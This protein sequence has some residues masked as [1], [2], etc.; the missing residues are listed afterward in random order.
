MTKQEV[1]D[2]I[3]E[4]IVANGSNEITANVLRPILTAILTQ[5]N[6]YIGD[7]EQLNTVEQSDLVSAINELAESITTIAN[8]GVKLHEG[9]SN[10]NDTTPSS[11]SIADFY[12]QKDTFN[13]PIQLWQ[14]NGISWI[15]VGN[16]INFNAFAY[17]EKK[18][19]YA[20]S[21]SFNLPN[22]VQAISVR[23]NGEPTD[24]NIEDWGQLG[25]VVTYL[26]TLEVGDY[27]IIGGIYNIEGGTSS[28]S[29]NSVNDDD[30]GVVSVDNS[31]Q[32]NPIIKFNGVY[33]DGTTVTGNGTEENP[34]ASLGGGGGVTINDETPSLTQT[35]S[36][37]KSEDT[38]VKRSGTEV[39][40]PVTGDVEIGDGISLIAEEVGGITSFLK[41]KGGKWKIEI[42][43][44][45][46]D[47]VITFD[48]D[49]GIFS[50]KLFDIENDEKAYLQKG[51]IIQLEEDVF[52]LEL[53]KADLVGGL[54]PSSQLPAYVDDI[55]E[56]YLLSGVF[57]KENTH[58]TAITG[59]IGKIYVDLTT[60]QKSRQY[61]WSGTVYIQITNGLIASTDDVIEGSNLYFTTARVLATVLTGI[62]FLT[63]GAI[64]STDSILV[65]FG[66]VQ[67]QLNDFSTAIGLKQDALTDT[68]FGT[69]TN[70]VAD[71]NTQSDTDVLAYVDITTGKWVKQTFSNFVDYLKGFFQTSRII[72]TSNITAVNGSIYHNNGNNT[73]TDP[74]PENNKGFSVKVISGTATIGGIDFGIGTIIERDYDGTDWKNEVYV[75]AKN[76][77]EFSG[78]K[79]V[80]TTW[81]GKE[82]TCV[83]SGVL[84]IPASLPDE[85]NFCLRADAGVSISWAITSPHTW[86]VMGLAVGVA[87]ATMTAGQF[88][89]VSKRKGTSE[90]RIS[91]L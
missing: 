45:I 66:K 32:T 27:L 44:G 23:K 79:T 65:A 42:E 62:S 48:I 63:G 40:K 72:V 89:Q 6:N 56:G 38:F 54:V 2:L 75:S 11:Y 37:E 51:H 80:V 10:P 31:N 70:S 29:V 76:Q 12:I 73:F 77:V 39:G 84:T 59:E 86:R 25:N 83:S 7:L 67:K 47:I 60:G 14:F 55:I 88:C 85:F 26:G 3:N 30:N 41:S 90:I 4:F 36:S 34:L 18:I 57:Y 46:T 52:N 21:N 43:D 81:F 68:N 15:E 28:G 19:F 1:L 91:G 5:P 24:V 35:Y 17:P 69:F 16:N 74:T 82:V 53:N 87:P 61:R 78:N 33:V 49:K 20:G 13:N 50:D 71:K 9:I 58:T 22:N 64:V 8:G